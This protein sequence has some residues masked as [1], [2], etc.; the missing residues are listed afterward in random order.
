MLFFIILF[1]QG[2]F[3]LSFS[4]FQN[5]WG[6]A[7]LFESWSQI[8]SDRFAFVSEKSPITLCLSCECVVVNHNSTT[9]GTG[10]RSL[11]CKPTCIWILCCKKCARD[12]HT[13]L[14]VLW[15]L[16]SAVTIKP[17]SRNSLLYYIT[18]HSWHSVC[19]RQTD[20]SP[21]SLSIFASFPS[22]CSYLYLCSSDWINIFYLNFCGSFYSIRS[23]KIL[24]EA[25]VDKIG[26]TPR[27]YPNHAAIYGLDPSISASSDRTQTSVPTT[28][29]FYP[30]SAGNVVGL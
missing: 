29:C 12:R 13:S 23:F 25:H 16:W 20:F 2:F 7:K 26:P 17:F 27:T 4:V 22:P 19:N 21:S 15:T 24:K 10:M 1:T 11:V 5:V 3:N 8:Y 28:R 9:G 18:P 6:L 14:S 30:N